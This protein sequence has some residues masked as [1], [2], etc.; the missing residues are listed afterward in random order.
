MVVM[1]RIPA[2]PASAKRAFVSKQQ[3]KQRRADARMGEAMQQ[4]HD[5]GRDLSE[6]CV[7]REVECCALMKERK[8]RRKCDLSSSPSASSSSASLVFAERREKGIGEWGERER[9]ELLSPLR[10]S[11]TRC[12]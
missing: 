9:R 4:R 5:V 7:F 8:K 2:S 11:S 1:V 10:L 6:V 3:R 12:R